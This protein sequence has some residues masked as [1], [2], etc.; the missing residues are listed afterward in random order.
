MTI[1]ITATDLSSLTFVPIQTTEITQRVFTAITTINAVEEQH[2][3]LV[4]IDKNQNDSD[5]DG[6]IDTLNAKFSLSLINNDSTPVL[7]N[8]KPIKITQ[9]HSVDIDKIS[10]GTIDLIEWVADVSNQLIPM[11]VNKKSTLNSWGGI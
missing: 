11:V 8:D 5:G 1:Q 2:V 3:V 9:V 4:H 7:V 10:D 6:T